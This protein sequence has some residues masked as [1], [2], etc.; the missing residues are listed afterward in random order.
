MAQRII[1]GTIKV[2]LSPAY[3]PADLERDDEC[4]FK[5]LT[6][7]TSSMS[8]YGYAVIGTAEIT[9]TLNDTDTIIGDKIVALR[10]EAKKVQADATKRC[11]D[12]ESQVQQL[13]AIPMDTGVSA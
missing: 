11:T 6:F 4:V 5:L 3:G 8:E 10:A 12:I 7:V 2:H 1:K 13:L 9:V